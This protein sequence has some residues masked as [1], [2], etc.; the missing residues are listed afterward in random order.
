MKAVNI[1]LGSSSIIYI[2]VAIIGVISF[3]SA[4]EESIL[5]N[6]GHD[7]KHWESLVIRIIFLLVLACHIPFIFYTGKESALIMLDEFQ[8]KSISTHMQQVVQA[9]IRQK[10]S[11]RVPNR[12]ESGSSFM[13]AYTGL[14]SNFIS[15]N[16]A[17]LEDSVL[18]QSCMTH[19]DSVQTIR[20]SN[21][22]KS[23]MKY[24]EMPYLN[25]LVVTLLIYSA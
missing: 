17:M 11:V 19:K 10:D 3:G 20:T 21:A 1:A 13:S 15:Y 14:Q 9:Q 2:S 7:E 6:V 23:S 18:D 4:V 5:Q 25:Y 24:M 22:R 8:R 12:T 16:N